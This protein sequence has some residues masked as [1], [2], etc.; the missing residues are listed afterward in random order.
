MLHL[1]PFR[2]SSCRL[3]MRALAAQGNRAG[4]L[5][6]YERFR[7]AV[8]DELG[9]DPAAETEEVYLEVLRSR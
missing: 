5:L 3:L 2:E 6:V 8:A 7:A 9:A 1:D 4:A